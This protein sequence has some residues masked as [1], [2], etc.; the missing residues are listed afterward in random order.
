[1]KNIME[2][3]NIVQKLNGPIKP[4]G[5]TNGDIVRFENLKNQCDLVF[6][7]L[8]EIIDVSKEK[9]RQEHSIS[10]AGQ[11]A[12]DFIHEVIGVKEGKNN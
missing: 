3:K 2:L 10:R 1:M 7:L 11:Y 5:E 6:E 4:L 9:D 12:Y 8:D